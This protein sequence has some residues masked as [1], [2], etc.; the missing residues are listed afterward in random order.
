LYRLPNGKTVLD[1]FLA[2]W[3]DLSAADKEMLRGWSDPVDRI[4][5][6]R[7]KDSDSLILLNLVDD[8]EYHTYSNIGPVALR[9]LPKRGFVYARLIPVGPV[10]DAW[11]VSGPMRAYHKSDAAQV[12]QAALELA[13]RLPELVHRNPEKVEQAGQQ[14]RR[15]R[16]AFVELFDSDETVLPPAEAEER[17]NG[18]YRHR[19]EAALAARP[20]RHRLPAIPGVDVPA[21]ELPPELAHAETIGVV[22]DEIDGLNFYNE[23]GMLCD[24]FADPALASDKR[25]LDV[26]RGYLRAPTIGPL[27]FRRLAT[28]HPQT[29]DAVFRKILRQ[30]HFTW[31]EH[32]EALMRRR[33]PWYFEHEPRPDRTVI[34]ARLS[35]LI[36]R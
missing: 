25:Y 35:E 6:I 14:M 2:G 10:P 3:P 8:Q 23:S 1:Q 7:G 19:Q 15:D 9:P 32:G 26:L 5:E 12:A 20:A 18:F 24:L 28:A 17:I 30:P 29:V 21:F 13:T 4:F 22:Y 31:A 16:A 11:L 27:P 36:S 33:R 34:G